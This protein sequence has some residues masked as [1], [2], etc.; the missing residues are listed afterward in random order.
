M[1][2]KLKNILRG[3]KAKKEII[4]GVQILT[5]IIGDTLGPRGR[6][7]I[8][9]K[10]R[11]YPLI[12]NDGASIAREIFLTKPFQDIGLNIVKE[13]SLKT[14]EE[15]GDSTTT[16]I[17]LSGAILESGKKYL[18]NGKNTN[19][20]KDKFMEVYDESSNFLD[21]ISKTKIVPEDVYNLAYISSGNKIHANII[22]KIYEEGNLNSSFVE[23]NKEGKTNYYIKEGITLDSGLI[24]T[25]MY[26]KDIK[27]DEKKTP[28]ILLFD[29]EFESIKNILE[30]LEDIKE[31]NESLI[32]IAKEFSKEATKS[33]VYNY[34]NDILDI[35][36]VKMPEYFEETKDFFSDFAICLNSKIYTSNNSLEN[37]KKE[38]LSKLENIKFTKDKT[39]I[40][41]EDK[42]VNLDKEKSLEKEKIKKQIKN[43]IEKE[44]DKSKKERL[45]KRLSIYEG[46]I[47]IIGVGNAPEAERKNEILK[48]EDAISSVLSAI[49]G[50]A[51]E[52]GGLAFL[53]LSK[54][55][56]EKIKSAKKEFKQK[57]KEKHKLKPKNDKEEFKVYIDALKI[58]SVAL[59]VPFEKIVK[60]SGKKPEKIYRQIKKANFEKGFDAETFEF[61]N[62]IE[63]GII[64]SKLSQKVALKNAITIASMILTM[65]TVIYKDL[66][67]D[68]E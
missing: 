15:M 56:E 40:F 38:E 54:C 64:D 2:K 5:N 48:L 24:S 8:I 39:Y 16:A 20:L 25:Y 52:G 31:N 37:V 46:K 45:K 32:I 23:E 62:M 60:N 53:K 49:K 27:R 67:F 59:K 12:T 7:V 41:I 4:K 51:L 21:S 55:L 47:S 61:V 36:A 18:K 57:E 30:L 19:L 28:Y 9:D 14:N 22:R 44:K 11:D 6:N 58:L 13:A 34:L 3:K 65:S 33:I 35:Y 1:A 68:I 66:D 26:N 17:V 63:K 43:E 42:K 10:G 50:G 29:G